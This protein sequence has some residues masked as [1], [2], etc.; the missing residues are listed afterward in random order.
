M[1]YRASNYNAITPMVKNLLIVN[2]LMFLIKVVYAQKF[3]KDLN[4]ILGLHNPIMSGDFKPWQILTHF[5]MH[6]DLAHLFSNMLGLFFFGRMLEIRWGGQRFLYFYMITA[7]FAALL[8]F[9]VQQLEI[10]SLTSSINPDIVESI[11]T[12]INIESVPDTYQNAKLYSLIH[13]VSYGASG[14]IFGILGACFV[15]FP[16]T[17][18]YLIF[19]PI[20]IKLKVAVTLYGLYELYRGIQNN[21]ADN[22]AH[23]AHLGGLVA[24]I[25]I[26]KYWNKTRRDSFY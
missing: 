18:L 3:G 7:F 11:R 14:A 1:Q 6:H 13:S 20:P 2:G 15:L 26:V 21:P 25:I 8:H 24:G 17:I 19:P 16:N 5:F 4:D 12:G 9:G 23:F 10:M 22:V